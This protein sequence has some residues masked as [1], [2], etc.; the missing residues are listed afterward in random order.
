MREVRFALGYMPHRLWG[1]ILQA[2]FIEKEL[3]KEFFVPREYI[4]NDE[5]TAAFQRLTPMQR[6]VIQLLDAFSDRNLHR[7]FSKKRTVKE[8]QDT[9]DEATIKNHIRPYIDKYIYTALEIVR[10]NRIT[11]FII[12]KGNRNVFPEDFLLVEKMAA[13]PVFSFQYGDQL[14]YSL[15]LVHGDHRLILQNNFVEVISNS[16]C[17]MILGKSIYFVHE[18]D[19]KKLVPFFDKEQMV[20]PKAVEKKYFSTFVRNTLREFKTL[21]EGFPVAELLPSM[22][23][24]L[25]LEVGMN[26]MPVWILAYHYNNQQIYPDSRLT[27]FVNYTG[28]GKSHGFERFAR[29]Y[30]WEEEM[31]NVLNEVGLRSRDQKI[32]YLNEKFNKGDESDLHSA[33]SFMNEAG[34]VLKEAGMLVRSRLNRNYY[35]G[36]IKLEM[37]SR[38][39]EDWFDVYAVVRFGEQSIPF[40]SLRNHILKGNREYKL[41]G[42]EIAVLPEEWFVRY[43]SMF[44]F[45]K[46]EGDHI[47]IHMQHFSLVEDSISG[48]HTETLLR[49]QKLNE[50]EN[51]P[52]FALPSGLNAQLRS[53][54]EEGYKWMCFLQQNGLGGCLADDMGLGKTLQALVAVSN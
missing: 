7:L 9:V 11:I 51:L 35:L 50:V 1:N 20:I 45:G 32:F 17:T 21:T 31:V 43:R 38:E 52:A 10:D 33:I 26:N 40:L 39:K 29:N 54:Q 3:E 30:P 15:S 4:Q 13:D 27:R 18:I 28:N 12:D 8:F 44:E 6:E 23:A 34:P 16:P 2:Q 24:E 14:T 47:R 46:V 22:T 42:G 36:E 48:F 53:Y 49:L 25:V 19:G 5:S 37:E 41:P